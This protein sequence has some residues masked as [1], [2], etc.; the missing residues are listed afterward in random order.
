MSEKN[1]GKT[2]IT[3]GVFD[4][5]H[6]GHFELFRRAKELVGNEGKLIV[7]VQED[8]VVT[9][10][11]PETRLVYDWDTRAKMIRA[12]R[13]V[14]DVV[15]YGDIDESIKNIEFDIFIVGGD[16]NHSGFQRAIAW[17]RENGKQVV[18]LPRTEGISATKI[19]EIVKGL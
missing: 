7:G 13:Y 9:K 6:F 10:Y 2:A 5:L 18:S 19:K 15:S 14:D 1:K 17:C 3:F 16:Q 12:L 8:R 4:L 11:K